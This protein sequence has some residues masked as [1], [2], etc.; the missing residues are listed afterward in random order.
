MNIQQALK[1]VAVNGSINIEKALSIA[2]G[3]DHER[4]TARDLLRKCE[5]QVGMDLGEQI[6]VHIAGMDGTR[7][8]V[9]DYHYEAMPADQRI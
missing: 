3:F 4:E 8:N 1:S 9:L 6:N 2:A 5:R 7:F